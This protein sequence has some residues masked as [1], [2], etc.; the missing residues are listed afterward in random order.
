MVKKKIPE[1]LKQTISDISIICTA[2]LYR[3]VD[4]VKIKKNIQQAVV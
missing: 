2:F 4:K 1:R 3:G